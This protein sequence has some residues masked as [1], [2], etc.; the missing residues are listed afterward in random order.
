MKYQYSFK[1]NKERKRNVIEY[2]YS[3]GRVKKIKLIIGDDY[4]KVSFE[5]NTKKKIEDFINFNI[6]PVRDAYVK[7]YLLHAIIKKRGLKINQI[8]CQIDDEIRK[9][10]KSDKNFPF[11]YSM[12]PNENID[13][14]G[15]WEE[16]GSLLVHQTKTKM[17][18]DTRYSAVY[19]YLMSKGREFEY[20]R[21]QNLWTSMNS[22]YNYIGICYEN[23]VCEDLKL[24]SKN[25]LKKGI[26]ISGK[27]AVC[28]GAFSYILGGKYRKIT[29]E[30]SDELKFNY[31][32]F[33]KEI[34]KYDLSDIPYLYDDFKRMMFQDSLG[35]N[36][37]YKLLN[38]IIEPFDVSLF[39][40]MILGYPYYW[41][42]K[43]F[44]GNKIGPLFMAHNEDDLK[45]L[46]VINYFMDRFLGEY[47][48]MV[49]KKE[50]WNENKYK[51]VL[52]FLEK[53]ETQFYN[54]YKKES[55]KI[56]LNNAGGN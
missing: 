44:H 46:Y 30:I 42:C 12:I 54:S 15:D 1:I 38:Q 37:Q 43:Y 35:N 18:K 41:R 56:Q 24:K 33:E 40:F 36:D 26:C 47:I 11:L 32:D 23:S 25:E 17:N 28:I 13:L 34:C 49:F 14:V 29:P 3:F 22:L 53:Y 21:F 9:F 20:Y 19:S 16:L 50:Y 51:L 5:M 55:K 48:P 8:E 31:F 7:C 2:E 10:D 45:I 27:D 52:E 6:L 4:A 39:V